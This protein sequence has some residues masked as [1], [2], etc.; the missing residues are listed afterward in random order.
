MEKCWFSQRDFSCIKLGGVKTAPKPQ[1]SLSARI[2]DSMSEY[3]VSREIQWFLNFS[4]THGCI[5]LT[6]L[7]GKHYNDLLD[8]RISGRGRY[9]VKYYS[10]EYVFCIQIGTTYANFQEKV[11]P[12][13]PG[14]KFQILK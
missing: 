7:L 8:R 10:F 1:L 4:V 5:S 13:T 11:F 9:E 3:C 6:T 12:E 2:S 14:K